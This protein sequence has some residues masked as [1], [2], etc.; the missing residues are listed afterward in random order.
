MLCF[1]ASTGWFWSQH[2]ILNASLQDLFV[3]ADEQNR[4]LKILDNNEKIAEEAIKEEKQKLL[5]SLET[6][7][8]FSYNGDGWMSDRNFSNGFR[9]PIPDFGNNFALEAK[10]LIYAGGAASAGI[11]LARLGHDYSKLE[12]EKNRQNIRFAITGYYLEMLKLQNQRLV[13]EKNIVQTQKMIDQIQAKTNQGVALKNN[14]TRYELQLQSLNVS[15]LQLNNSVTLLNNEL[16]KILNLPSG[17][18]LEL[19]KEDTLEDPESVGEESWKE[20]ADS[21][22]PLLKQVALSIE[23]SRKK[24]K[25]VKSEKLPQVFAF[26]ADYLDGPI[27]VEVPPI[28]KNLN[29]WYVGVGIKYNIS[30]LYK[31]ETK[32]KQARLATLNVQENESRVKEQLANDV[33]A[34][35]I[36]Y[37]ETI[38]IY[39][40]RLKNIELATQNYGVVKSR[41]LNDLALITE[42]LDAEN[43]KIDAELQAANAQ[44]NILF[45]YYQLKKLSGTL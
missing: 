3:L 25:I 34:A 8:F 41:Y 44:I 28:N 42:M 7:L 21:S 23:M 38:D 31:N 15:L 12:T 9:A 27:M 45:H 35:R 10:Q 14:V 24:E 13:I 1:L 2:P 37:M 33:E 20:R 30:S 5:P 17:T 11:E 29:Y 18:L 16:V 40:T 6:S 22:S 19:K 32:T 36:K 39:K 43:T 26:A 4:D